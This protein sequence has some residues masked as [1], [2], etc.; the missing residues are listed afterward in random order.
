[1]KIK[2]VKMKMN[3]MQILQYVLKILVYVNQ[4]Y[5][6]FVSNFDLNT[7]TTGNYGLL[8]NFFSEIK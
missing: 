6:M 4:V 8:F 5:T 7:N 2:T 1:M 3:I